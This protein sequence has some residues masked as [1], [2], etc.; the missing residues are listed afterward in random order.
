MAWDTKDCGFCFIELLEIPHRCCRKW[1]ADVGTTLLVKAR[2]LVF[3]FFFRKQATSEF[4][5]DWLV[6]P[7]TSEPFARNS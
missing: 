7:L 1:K 3:F 5:K 4:P 6:L 2:V